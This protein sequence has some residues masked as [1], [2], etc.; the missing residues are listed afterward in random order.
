MNAAKCDELD[1]IHSL[2]AAKKTFTCTE[3][4]RCQPESQ[5]TPAHD[6]F[7]RLLQRQPLDKPYAQKMELLTYH[8]SGKHQRVV[9]D[10]ALDGWE[11]PHPLPLSVL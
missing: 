4:E 6:A 10:L 11:S 9:F 7:T 5:N 8:W 1:Y 3:A 2:I